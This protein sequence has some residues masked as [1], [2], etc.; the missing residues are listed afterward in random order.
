[1]HPILALTLLSA[2]HVFADVPSTPYPTEIVNAAL[3]KY[4][5]WEF[6]QK[7]SKVRPELPPHL[8]QVE[9]ILYKHWFSGRKSDFVTAATPILDR[10]RNDPAFTPKP[11]HFWSGWI[12]P[13]AVPRTAG[14]Y[15][16]SLRR[17]SEFENW[18]DQ[19][20]ED[21]ENETAEDD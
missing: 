14:D 11:K 10:I 21:Q 8:N 3:E 20:I 15:Y 18:R 2:V 17:I 19:E 5:E 1:M 6:T 4:L 12:K 9:D 16:D 7:P 13:E